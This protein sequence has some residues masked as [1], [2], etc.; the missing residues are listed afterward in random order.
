M[1][2][3][4]PAIVVSLRDGTSYV[5]R[6]A[7]DCLSVLGMQGQN[8]LVSPQHSRTL[9]LGYRGVPDKGQGSHAL[10]HRISKAYQ[11]VCLSGCDRL[12]LLSR[13]TR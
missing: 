2:A 5:R 11:T 10:R 8:P 7:I 3:A 9:T 1:Q 4:F 12:H 13:S 6:A